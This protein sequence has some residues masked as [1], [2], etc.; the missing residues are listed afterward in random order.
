MQVNEL[1]RCKRKGDG[2]VLLVGSVNTK[3]SPAQGGGH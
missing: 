3:K 2:F 1:Y